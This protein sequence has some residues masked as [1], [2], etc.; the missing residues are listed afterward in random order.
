MD[1]DPDELLA[2]Q[3]ATEQADELIA[4]QNEFLAAVGNA[5][6]DVVENGDYGPLHE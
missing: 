4:A 6:H 5:G 1:L 2:L 3:I